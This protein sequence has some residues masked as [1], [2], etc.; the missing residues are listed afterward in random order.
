MVDTKNPHMAERKFR[1]WNLTLSERMMVL[2]GTMAV[3]QAPEKV[4][5]IYLLKIKQKVV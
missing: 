2:S 3:M 4:G 5:K 1:G